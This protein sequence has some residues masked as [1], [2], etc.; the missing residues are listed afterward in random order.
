LPDLK[1]R[2]ELE[3]AGYRDQLDHKELLDHKDRLESELAGYR[4][5]LDHRDQVG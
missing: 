4:G 2:L 5:Q 1:D 3:L